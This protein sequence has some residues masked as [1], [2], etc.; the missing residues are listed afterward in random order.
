MQSGKICNRTRENVE[1]VDGMQLREGRTGPRALPYLT[2]VVGD[3]E[4]C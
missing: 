2:A 4:H 3:G 1:F